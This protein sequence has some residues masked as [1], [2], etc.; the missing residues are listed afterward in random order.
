MQKTQKRIY[1]KDKYHSDRQKVLLKTYQSLTYIQ[2]MEVIIV[3]RG[4]R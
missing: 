4:A 2:S 1:D 3:L